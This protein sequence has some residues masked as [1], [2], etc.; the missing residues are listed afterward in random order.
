MSFKSYMSFFSYPATALAALAVSAMMS[1]N[2]AV[3]DD[4][5]P[6]D[7]EEV[8]KTRLGNIV[9]AL[10]GYVQ[11]HNGMYPNDGG[12]VW[13]LSRAGLASENFC[14]P[15]RGTASTNKTMR[16]ADWMFN[17]HLL[18]VD[19]ASVPDRERVVMLLPGTRSG[20]TIGDSAGFKYNRLNFGAD[21]YV[22]DNG[23]VYVATADGKIHKLTDQQI[24]VSKSDG[25]PFYCM[26][27]MDKSAAPSE[28]ENPGNFELFKGTREIAQRKGSFTLDGV[29]S[30]A[31][32]SAEP[33]AR[34]FRRFEW[35][36]RKAVASEV[37]THVWCFYDD[38]NLYIGVKAFEPRMSEVHA[39]TVSDYKNKNIWNDEV[40]EVFVQTATM[41]KDQY[42]Q[43]C[44]S[45]SSAINER[46]KDELDRP[47]WDSMMRVGVHKD[48]DFWSMEMQIPLMNLG[49]RNVWRETPRGGDK[50]KFNFT[51][52]RTPTKTYSNWA[53]ADSVKGFHAPETFAELTFGGPRR[54]EAPDLASYVS[55][56]PT[57]FVV[58]VEGGGKMVYTA[59]CDYDK[60]DWR[61][62]WANYRR[63][64]VSALKEISAV[65]NPPKAL[66]D[67]IAVLRKAVS[68]VDKV[69][70]DDEIAFSRAIRRFAD[71]RVTVASF[72]RYAQLRKSKRR[73]AVLNPSR[74]EHLSPNSVVGPEVGGNRVVEV[75]MAAN[76]GEDV[77]LLTVPLDVRC[78]FATPVVK[79]VPAGLE[80]AVSKMS[81]FRCC[82]IY[83]P[84]D[85][86]SYK[87]LAQ[88]ANTPQSVE[89]GMSQCWW[90]EIRTSPSAAGKKLSFKI[91]FSDGVES[92]EVVVKV[93]VW[94]FTLPSAATLTALSWPEPV[95]LKLKFSLENYK[96]TW[97]FVKRYRMTPELYG[98]GT[99]LIQ[100]LRAKVEGNVYTYDFSPLTPYF[101][102][103]KSY[104]NF[105]FNPNFSCCHGLTDYVGFA[106]DMSR[107]PFAQIPQ[108]KAKSHAE[109][110]Q[111][112]ADRWEKYLYFDNP[113]DSPEQLKQFWV[114]YDKY[115]SDIGVVDNA[116]Y[117]KWDEC[118]PQRYPSMR[119]D[120]KMMDKFA[121]HVKKFY[122]RNNPL[123]AEQR[124][125]MQ[126][127]GVSLASLLAED[128]RLQIRKEH[129]LG[130][131]CY[132]YVCGA[133][134]V[135]ADT[136]DTNMDRPRLQ[137]RM[138]SWMS[139]AW[140]FDGFM[141]FR[142][143]SGDQFV[144]GDE[145][146]FPE[147]H[148]TRPNTLGSDKR[149]DVGFLAWNEK[150]T[151]RPFEMLSSIRDGQEDYEYVRIL[152]TAKL[153]GAS[154]RKRDALLAEI[155]ASFKS[156]GE[157]NR[158]PEAFVRW[159]RQIA[160]LI[161]G[162]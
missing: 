52:N 64:A 73:F 112:I 85:L 148:K 63:N 5:T 58:T 80:V 100:L 69:D 60:P 51:R 17:K 108:K 115:L 101:E 30:E 124:S 118:S 156:P 110:M 68:D 13:V 154:A 82:D 36:G 97:D 136:P 151:L 21:F 9:A 111:N 93:N 84:K 78:D 45:L 27:E 25:K 88:S 41:R 53:P 138:F 8:V 134:V 139:W 67:S 43:L 121:P 131:P 147:I 4:L 35:E 56:T 141:V 29:L 66:A 31:E 95:D 24:G 12:W 133:P 83:D 152:E 76:E 107:I 6:G 79:D 140:G 146:S 90:F 157:F 106:T 98:A 70:P 11:T 130:K 81:Y 150:G 92:R 71:R 162:L 126:M 127:W 55:K 102:L 54:C 132:F 116:M 87:A 144:K 135:S 123:D 10:D 46:I 99:N 155:R 61:E 59:L 149:F 113:D 23:G 48:A 117:E 125:L 103:I 26:V 62:M 32:Y 91:E 96:K 145:F 22:K 50:W 158:D 122:W 119:R 142:F 128:M 94:N 153:S 143:A 77:Q 104:G 120:H 28:K 44:V 33:T 109:H 2:V 86:T 34:G 74:F 19:A 3:A 65:K 160:R 39:D 47:S 129:N 57:N 15:F 89:P 38:K 161:E 1:A 42:A 75:E 159:R 105:R 18:R 114:Q 37:D 20:A 49:W 72:F 7:K 40:I 14:N 16:T 137:R